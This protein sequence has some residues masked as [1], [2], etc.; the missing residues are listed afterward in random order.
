MAIFRNKLDQRR[1]VLRPMHA[2]GRRPSAC[3]TVLQAPDVSQIHALV[4]WNRVAWEIVD[5]SRN[6]TT[7][8]GERLTSGRWTVVPPGAEIQLGLGEES[9]W[10][11][12][13]LAPPATCLFPSDG[14]GALMALSPRENLLPDT[15]QPE[16]N[17]CFHEGRWV[18]EHIDGVDQL[19][20]GATVR[21]SSGSWEFVLCDDL[22]STA[23]NPLAMASPPPVEVALHFDVSQDEEH[24]S[25]R[26]V[27]GGKSVSLG[28]RIHHYT[29]VTLARVRSEDAQ[30]G[31]APQSQ[32]WIALDELSRMLGV[33]PSYVN[34]QI[35]RAKHQILNALPTNSA[36][37]P[38]V[39]RRRGDVR[40]GSYPF[41]IEGGARR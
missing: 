34:I 12:E 24:T 5:Q 21:T 30:R 20:D 6:G 27:A 7:L 17:V 23:E 31:L 11:A 2:F 19:S 3:Q 8:N 29:L 39:E 22:E 9:I 15:Q 40:F 1:T 35:F 41:L 10:V 38:L 36:D 28:E 16:V 14:Q 26:L 13:D 33:E 32:G 25:L 18:L 37:A 4:R